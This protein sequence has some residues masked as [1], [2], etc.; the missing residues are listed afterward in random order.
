MKTVA[1]VQNREQRC[2]DSSHAGVE[3]YGGRCAWFERQD[4]IFEDLRVGMVETGINEID[5]LAR[6]PL[7]SA[8]HQIERSLRRLRAREDIRRTTKNGRSGGSH[9]E[10]WIE[11]SRENVCLGTEC[12]RVLGFGH[13]L[14]LRSECSAVSAILELG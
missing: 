13:I 10:T 9:G 11:A 5:V 6:S 8:T 3:Y 14:S 12:R 7:G 2:H 1:R 4:L